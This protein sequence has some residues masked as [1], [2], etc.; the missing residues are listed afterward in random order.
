MYIL[1]TV[2]GQ[3]SYIRFLIS[4]ISCK[5]LGGI[6]HAATLFRNLH[7]KCKAYASTARNLWQVWLVFYYYKTFSNRSVFVT[8]FP[9]RIFKIM[10][11]TLRKRYRLILNEIHKYF[12]FRSI[13]Y[14]RWIEKPN[15][16]SP[17]FPPMI[18]NKSSASLL[19]ILSNI[20]ISV[21]NF[22]KRLSLAYRCNDELI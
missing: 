18:N 1:V 5:L 10:L 17:I 12:I 13:F 3:Q 22:M 6:R 14:P 15:S 4:D 21:P 2:S 9:S 8:S 11:H 7:S 16:L 20:A 19:E